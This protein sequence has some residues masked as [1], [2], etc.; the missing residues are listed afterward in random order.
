VV[1]SALAYVVVSVVWVFTVRAK[2]RRRLAGH[3]ERS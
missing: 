2:R 1:F 3:G